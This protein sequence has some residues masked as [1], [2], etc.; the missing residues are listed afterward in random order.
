MIAFRLFI[1]FLAF[2]SAPV[3]ADYKVGLR[4][5]AVFSDC[6]ECPE[7]VVIPPGSF[8]MGHDGG[9]SEDRYE[10][11]QHTVNISYSF[12]FG[13][14]EITTSQF[15]E[16]VDETDHTAGTNCSMWTGKTIENI[17][18]NDWRNPGYGRPPLD[19]DPAACLDW[20]DAKAYA[21]WLAEKTGQP[22]RLPTEAEWEYVAHGGGSTT[23]AWGENPDGGCEVANYYDQSA[24][25]LRPWDTAAC[26]DGNPMVAP[27]GSLSPN[28]FGIYDVIG[29]VWEWT[30]DCHVVPYGVQPTDGSAHQVAGSCE[31][32]VMRGGA[33][34]S[35]ATWQRPT[36]RG[37][38]PEDFVTQV[39]GMR[40]VRDLR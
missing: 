2:A 32:R 10:G 7:M 30:E 39:F 23:Y 19:E 33:W 35:R 21:A 37:R 17:D 13:L 28:A 1:V 8:V 25:G 16:F 12:A 5:S 34:H 38:D 29:N 26:N 9:V 11:P 40:V 18:G 4:P 6:A 31:K 27:V 22:Y 3:H 20:H 14:L 15:R 24:A 36:F